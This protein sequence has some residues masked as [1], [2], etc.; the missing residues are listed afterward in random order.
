MKIHG[1]WTQTPNAIYA[2]IPHMR[3]AELLC[4]LVL[5]R[6]TYGYHRVRARI[7]YAQFLRDTG[8]GSKATVSRG[9]RAVE[10]RGFFERTVVPSIWQI[11]P[12][13]EVQ[14]ENHG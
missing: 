11:A 10:Q 1:G 6:E 7:T 12:T 14:E 2:A 13:I 9:L 5:V 4:T 3:T 8:I